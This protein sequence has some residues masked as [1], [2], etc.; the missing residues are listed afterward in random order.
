[1][2]PYI[3]CIYFL[4]TCL[5]IDVIQP[6]C[7]WRLKRKMSFNNN[8]KISLQKQGQYLIAIEYKYFDGI[9]IHSSILI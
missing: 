4:I 6:H 9:S 5:C 8:E 2:L 7:K 1:M 3:T